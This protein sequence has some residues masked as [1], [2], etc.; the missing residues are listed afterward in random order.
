[1]TRAYLAFTD[2]GLALARRLAQALPGS[3]T[4]CGK[5]VSLTDWT[6]VQFAQ[7]DALIFVGA[8]GI[9]VRAPMPTASLQWMSGPGIKTASCWNRSASSLSAANCWPGSR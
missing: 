3:V 8:V 5:D 2:T 4:R 1:M 6:A 7:S 9:A